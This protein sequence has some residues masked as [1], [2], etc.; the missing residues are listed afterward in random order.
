MSENLEGLPEEQSD[1]ELSEKQLLKRFKQEIKFYESKADPWTRRV[2][3]IVKRY[4]DERSPRENDNAKYNILWSNIQLLQP[5]LFAKN[6]VPNIERRN[7]T[8][9]DLGRVTSQ[10]LERSID[11]FVDDKFFDCNKQAVLDLLLPGR[12]TVWVRYEPKFETAQPEDDEQITEDAED[13]EYLADEKVCWDF[14]HMSDFG[15]SWGRVWDEVDIVWRKVPMT[16]PEMR[17]RFTDIDVEDIPLDYSELDGKDQK[18]DQVQKKAVIYELWDKNTNKAYWLNTKYAEGFLDVKDDPLGLYDFFPCP[19]P[20]FATLA[21]DSCIPTPDYYMYQDQAIELDSVTGRLSA[22]VKAI[23]VAGI[24]DASAQ[25]VQRLLSEGVENQLIPV[26]Q[27]AMLSE[28][29]GIKGVMELMPMQEILETLSGLYDA[30]EKIKQDIYEITGISDILRGSSDPNETYGAQ[31]LKSQ[32]GTLRLSSRQDEVQRFCRELIYIGSQII[33]KHF[34]QDTIKNI[35]NMTLFTEQ[36]KQLVQM[37]AQYKQQM[38]QYQQMMQKAQQPPQPGQPGQPPQ[39]PMMQPQ[40]P[41]PPQQPM[42][43][44]PYIAKLDPDDIED[45]MNEPS[46]DEVMQFMHSDS[47][48]NYR[49]DIETDSTIKNDQEAD[50]A[51]RMEFLSAAGGFIKEAMAVQDPA[52]APL[53]AK[54]MQFGLRGFKVGR[55][56]ESEF[57][58]TIKKIE[59]EAQN[60]QPKPNPE[61]MKIQAQ[62]Q[63]QQQEQQAD[64]Q[65]KQLQMQNDAKL[66]QLK[67]EAE[68]RRLQMQAQVDAH[69]GQVDAEVERFKIQL[70]GELDMKK[71]MMDNETKIA[72]AQINAKTTLQNTALSKSLE[73]PEVDEGGNVVQKTTLS[74]L[75]DQVNQ[76]LAQLFQSIQGIGQSHAMMMDQMNQPKQLVRDGNGNV[77][78]VQQGQAV[79]RVMRDEQGN[80]VGVQ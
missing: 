18:V 15:H 66:E 48:I 53:L 76:S 23:K 3:K 62:A 41:P 46:W 80:I 20:L 57:E 22:I 37:N 59:K 24:Y 8:K 50:K 33:A 60:P 27:W 34:D 55:D 68:D 1:D 11:F 42:P 43:V 70:Q 79:K 58:T 40:L 7:R 74:S 54:M 49:I 16:K 14:V 52:I 44:P 75:S 28:K 26:D 31:R 13:Q 2:K 6:P 45:I 61:M 77:V 30:R 65:M 17:A 9:D 36:E 35:S 32:F 67:S 56:L 63:L 12:G 64:A 47:I 5:A 69:Q 19:K 72:V 73:P 78:G 4:K 38:Q 10:V 21:N 25:G 51:A 71:A 29:G 39:Q